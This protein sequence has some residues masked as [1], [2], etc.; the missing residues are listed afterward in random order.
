MRVNGTEMSLT[1]TQEQGY[2]RVERLWQPG[3]T[4]VLNLSM[5]IE[6]VYAHPDVAADVGQVAL[7]RGPLVYCLEEVDQRVPLHRILVHD[8]GEF[9]LQPAADLAEGVSAIT[10]LALALDNAGWD[11]V[12]YRREP[13]AV[14]PCPITAIPY[15]AWD[16]RDGGAM[17]VWLH[18]AHAADAQ[19][20]RG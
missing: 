8:E 16:N 7:Q 10:G 17:R 20:E 5:R 19:A 9:R 4:V 13:P 6:R 15:Y 1:D 12:L 11:G 18:A 14:Q 3:D 2:V